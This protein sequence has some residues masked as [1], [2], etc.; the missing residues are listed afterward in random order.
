MK[1]PI[2]LTSTTSPRALVIAAHPHLQHSCANRALMSAAM[3]SGCE[4]RD[5]YALYP[6]PTRT[7]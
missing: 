6:D 5:L 7:A 1:T 4:V 2:S 3:Q